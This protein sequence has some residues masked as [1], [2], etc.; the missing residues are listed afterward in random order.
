MTFPIIDRVCR[1]EVLHDDRVER[2]AEAIHRGYCRQRLA[3]GDTPATNPAL[4]LVKA[5]PKP[6]AWRV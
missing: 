3:E 4:A 1:P 5:K 6:N 2:L